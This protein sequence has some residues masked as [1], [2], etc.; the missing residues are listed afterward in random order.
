M[1]YFYEESLAQAVEGVGCLHTSSAHYV[2]PDSLDIQKLVSPGD[3][4]PE[5]TK[6]IGITPHEYSP[7]VMKR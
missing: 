5:R 2:S 7:A 3:P 6:A 1:Q 4:N